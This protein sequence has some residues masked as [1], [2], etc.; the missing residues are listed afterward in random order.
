VKG[1][2]V[3]IWNLE[4]GIL[5]IGSGLGGLVSGIILA[6]EGYSV[7]ILEKN[8]QPGGNLQSFTRNGHKFSTG[9]HYIGSMDEGQTLHR[10][11]KYLGITGKV[12]LKKL[13]EI[14]YD[15]LT[16]GEEETVYHH[17]MGWE[18]FRETLSQ[19][20]P[21]ERDAI[22]RYV[23]AIRDSIKGIPLYDLENAYSSDLEPVQMNRC[24]MPFINSLTDDR[25]LTTV[26][27]GANSIYHGAAQRTPLYLHS[28][29]RNSFVSSAWRIAGGSEKLVDALVEAFTAAGGTLI[30]DAK[31]TGF[32]FGGDDISA[33]VL[34]DGRKLF[35]KQFI[36]N[37]HPAVTLQMIPEDKVRRAYRQRI[38][39]LENSAG[40]FT[41]YLVFKPGFFP[42]QDF[43][44]FHYYS[45]DYFD[46][47]LPDG[48]WPHTYLVYTPFY[49]DNGGFTRTASILSFMHYEDYKKWDGLAPDQ[50]GQD[51][52]DFREMSSQKLLNEVEKKYPGIR[53]GIEQVYN[54]TPLTFTD[55]TGTPH[56]SG[57][58]IMKDCENPVRTIIQPRTKI[59][60]LFFT[61]Q[62][63]NIHGVVGTTV[64]AILTCSEFTGFRYLVDKII[65]A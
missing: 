53:S 65:H 54:S 40:F 49:E 64:N 7:C 4:F 52:L 43:N 20:F 37:M 38:Q 19:Q 51:Y 59:P 30:T 36:S 63:Q 56:G 60:N 62:N 13:D 45:A 6:K 22:S 47:L 16:F 44:H 5:I 29:I 35:G 3:G 27:A 33:A 23:N 50:R 42:Y 2:E 25:R 58:G 39:S 9:L 31:V 24:T 26:L 32:E 57:Y 1:G 48:Q 15:R 10:F 61:G 21:S 28:C 18:N 14:G 17:A 41:L 12:P 11:F 8:H 46:D 34:E 55:Y